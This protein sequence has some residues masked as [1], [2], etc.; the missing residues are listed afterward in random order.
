MP[1]NRKRGPFG[2]FKHPIC[3]KI[4]KKLKGD[5]LER[6]NFEKV[7]QCR[8]KLKGGPSGFFQHTFCHKTAKKNREGTHWGKIFSQKKSRS[9]EK[10]L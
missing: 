9:A 1:K 6:K 8:K 4:S 10:K 7:S 2:I 3:C 5:P